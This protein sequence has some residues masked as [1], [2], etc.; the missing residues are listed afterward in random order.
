MLGELTQVRAVAGGGAAGA[1]AA[2]AARGRRR[3]GRRAQ[4][5]G[6][7][8][9]LGRRDFYD[10]VDTQYGVRA[11]IGDVRG[12]G[13]GAVEVAAVLLGSFREAA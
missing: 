3:V 7:G 13:L 4:R 2:A 6:V 11:I 10:I 8:R 1:A 5:L 9:R 12:S